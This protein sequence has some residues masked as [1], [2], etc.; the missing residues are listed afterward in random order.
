MGPLSGGKS[1]LHVT[2][3]NSWSSQAR[4]RKEAEVVTVCTRHK[5][6]SP[7]CGFPQHTG[8]SLLEASCLVGVVG[9]SGRGIQLQL[10]VSDSSKKTRF[11]RSC[12]MNVLEEAA[13]RNLRFLF[14]TEELWVFSILTSS[15]WFYLAVLARVSLCRLFLSKP[16]CLMKIFI[17][18]SFWSTV[19][20]KKCCYPHFI[21]WEWL[22]QVCE[23][24]SKRHTERLWK[25]ADDNI[26]KCLS[27]WSF[28]L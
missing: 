1:Q 2:V 23:W 7:G 16:Y 14:F 26:S 8:L 12:W 11:S 24:Y 25:R 22:Q 21:H 4:C 13:M 9:S 5:S 18:L 28:L 3:L 6:G 20:V 15:V 10:L 19:E 17:C 27:P